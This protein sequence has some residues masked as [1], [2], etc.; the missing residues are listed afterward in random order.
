MELTRKDSFACMLPKA[1]KRRICHVRV[2]RRA[3]LP[4]EVGLTTYITKIRQLL[5]YYA[6]PIWGLLP[7]YLATEIK[8][9]QEICLRIIGHPKNTLE[10]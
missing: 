5:E 4:S 1:N 3:G 9:V 8:R 10:T 6:S 2:C 7:E